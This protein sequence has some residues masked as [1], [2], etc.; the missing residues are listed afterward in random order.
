MTMTRWIVGIRS[1]AVLLL[2]AAFATAPL[3]GG[4]RARTLR[5]GVQADAG[6]MD[7][8]AQ[9]IQTTLTLH[10]MVYDA[11]VTRDRQLRLAPG[12]ATGWELVDP[13][14]WRFRLRPNVRFH[15]GASFTAAAVRFSIER[16][17]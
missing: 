17:K 14:T 8:Q 3:H 9:N 10:S 2:S 1:A 16:A 12:L 13:T 11:L 5:I 15:D 4:P 6:T 7:P